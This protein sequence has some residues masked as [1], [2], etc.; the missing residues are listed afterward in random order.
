MRKI[1]YLS[2]LVLFACHTDRNATN[3]T[4]LKF[5][6]ESTDGG[7]YPMH[8]TCSEISGIDP[9]TGLLGIISD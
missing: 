4:T 8:F 2:V 6:N 9:C 3:H 1:L 7:Y 5:Y